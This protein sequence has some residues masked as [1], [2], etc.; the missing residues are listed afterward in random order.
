MYQQWIGI[1]GLL[2][3]LLSSSVCAAEV[4]QAKLMYTT[5]VN[6]VA[7]ST[8]N[9]ATAPV[10]AVGQ[11]QGLK[12]VIELQQPDGSFQSVSSSRI[13]KSGETFR[14]KVA[15]NA[16]GYVYVSNAMNSQK[17]ETI[18]PQGNDSMAISAHETLV[19]PKQGSFKFDNTPGTEVL[20]LLL[21]K[22]PLSLAP[23]TGVIV[24]NLN[25]IH[26]KYIVYAEDKPTS[27]LNTNSPQEIASYVLANHQQLTSDTQLQWQVKLQHQ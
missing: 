25:P 9:T 1:L 5:G 18:Y 14:L 11:A 22:Q 6:D 20:T 12:I 26:A 27:Q 2:G 16:K 13:F 8:Q 17:A 10:V 21:S 15:S 24:A 3:V 23:S 4:S 19:L 7:L